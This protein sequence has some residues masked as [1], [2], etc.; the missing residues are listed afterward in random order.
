MRQLLIYDRERQIVY[1]Q[2]VSRHCS[3]LPQG[4]VLVR[5]I[6][7]EPLELQHELG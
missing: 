5:V 7:F 1:F 4:K 6:K 2:G 3:Q